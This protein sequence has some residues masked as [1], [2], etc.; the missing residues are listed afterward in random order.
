MV[1]LQG[2]VHQD[3]AKDEGEYQED[4]EV[5]DLKPS[6][7]MTGSHP[8]GNQGPKGR[9]PDQS[10]HGQGDHPA[11]GGGQ[12]V[13]DQDEE[14]QGSPASPS[15]RTPPSTSTPRTPSNPRKT[16]DTR[17]VVCTPLWKRKSMQR[18]SSSSSSKGKKQKQ[19]KQATLSPKC[20]SQTSSPTPASPDPIDYTTTT[21][22]DLMSSSTERTCPGSP[23]PRKM[24]NIAKPLYAQKKAR[25]SA[26]PTEVVTKPDRSNGKGLAPANE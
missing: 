4:W 7:R 2:G 11:N 13:R 24:T 19:K 8:D 10:E 15:Q 20:M 5:P 22:G 23:M 17:R 1:P 14:V 6:L 12:E 18:M 16:P 21:P 25:T 26:Q 3:D 9:K